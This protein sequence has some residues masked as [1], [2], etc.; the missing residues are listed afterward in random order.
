MFTLSL[1]IYTYNFLTIFNYLPVHRLLPVS[2]PSRVVVQTSYF[3]IPKPVTSTHWWCVV[4]AVLTSVHT[5]PSISSVFLSV[6]IPPVLSVIVPS[7]ILSV[8][9]SWPLLHCCL[10]VRQHSLFIKISAWN[11]KIMKLH[12]LSFWMVFPTPSCLIY[13][14]SKLQILPLRAWHSS[15]PCWHWHDWGVGHT[16]MCLQPTTTLEKNPRG[17]HW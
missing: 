15:F 2:S 1:Y 12:I 4:T 10:S 8:L 11:K 13:H 3:G 16:C 6:I 7:I 9:V 14:L 5:A 17:I